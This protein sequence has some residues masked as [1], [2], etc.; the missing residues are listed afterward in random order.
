[1]AVF[2]WAESAKLTL[3]EEPRV[4]GAKFG[5]GYEQRLPDGINNMPQAWD[6]N[7]EQVDNAIADDITNF[8]RARAGW[9]AFDWTPKWGTVA[10]R[11][12]CPKWSRSPDGEALSRI[13][14]RFEQ[15]FE[16]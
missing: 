5:D 12:K 6:L 15:V 10:I 8:L 14:A 2:D 3:D 16:P 4:L 7:F 9:E 11:V 13:S 1:M